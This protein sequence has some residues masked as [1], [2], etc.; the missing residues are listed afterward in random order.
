MVT[1][2]NCR[3]KNTTAL[4]WTCA[5][6]NRVTKTHWHVLLKV[7]KKPTKKNK[8]FSDFVHIYSHAKPVQFSLKFNYNKIDLMRK[9][10]LVLNVSG[11]SCFA[12]SN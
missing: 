9:C 4:I 3:N 1:I 7:V 5:Y 12:E 2:E 11:Q 8:Y 6:R 10:L